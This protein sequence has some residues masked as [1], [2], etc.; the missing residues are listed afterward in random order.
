MTNKPDQQRNNDPRKRFSL[1]LDALLEEYDRAADGSSRPIAP[2]EEAELV[3]AKDAEIEDLK[4][5]VERLRTQIENRR[6]VEQAKWLIVEQI[7]CSEP[8]AYRMLQKQ[9]ARTN[10]KLHE[11][12]GTL[13]ESQ[14]IKDFVAAEA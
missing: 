14:E 8:V 4:K 5:E 10:R 9:A 12:A 2:G 6:V 11:I 7:K 1:L 13:V 3:A